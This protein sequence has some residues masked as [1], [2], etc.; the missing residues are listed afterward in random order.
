MLRR[1]LLLTTT[2]VLPIQSARVS[3][4]RDAVAEQKRT[5]TRNATP[6]G[7]DSNMAAELSGRRDSLPFALTPFVR[8]SLASAGRGPLLVAPVDRAHRFCAVAAL[9]KT[10][11]KTIFTRS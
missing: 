11:Y 2:G 4:E 10:I 3:C 1:G 6:Q 5:A 9:S 8:R 7:T